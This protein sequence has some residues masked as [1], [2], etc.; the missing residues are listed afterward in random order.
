MPADMIAHP[1]F[2]MAFKPGALYSLDFD[3]F[4]SVPDTLE[5]V[6]VLRW[7]LLI[8]SPDNDLWDRVNYLLGKIDFPYRLTRAIL[9]RYN[10]NS[11]P[12][13]ISGTQLQYNEEKKILLNKYICRRIP[14]VLSDNKEEALI[15]FASDNTH[16]P[17]DMIVEPGLLMIFIPTLQRYLN[18]KACCLVCEMFLKKNIMTRFRISSKPRQNPKDC[19]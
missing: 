3:E 16:M 10:I 1:G 7:D 13:G 8:M 17:P 19:L 18:G 4:K 12:S 6:E 15:V 9:E 2:L 5:Q 14:G 11:W